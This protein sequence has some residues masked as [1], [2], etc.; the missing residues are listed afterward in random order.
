MTIWPKGDSNAVSTSAIKGAST[1]PPVCAAFHPTVYSFR[2][3]LAHQLSPFIASF[4]QI[5]R[6]CSRAYCSRKI[7]PDLLAIRHPPR[8][9]RIDCSEKGVHN[10]NKG[11]GPHNFCLDFLRITDN[12]F[13]AD[14][15]LEKDEVAQ[16]KTPQP[17]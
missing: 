9:I 13:L 7:F 6:K 8:G 16:Q 11:S 15:Q 12:F 4:H 5:K 10:L 14:A 17:K 3:P 2:N 1:T